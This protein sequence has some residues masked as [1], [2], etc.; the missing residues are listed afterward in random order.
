MKNARGSHRV[1]SVTAPDPLG[2]KLI[3]QGPLGDVE[4]KG[5]ISVINGQAL[6]LRLRLAPLVGAPKGKFTAQV[7]AQSNELVPDIG[8]LV[9]IEVTVR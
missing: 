2:A 8:H 5:N 4:V 7:L 6:D 3:M 9:S 1:A